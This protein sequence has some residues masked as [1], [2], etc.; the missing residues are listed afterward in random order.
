MLEL[1]GIRVTSEYERRKADLKAA[2]LLKTTQ[3]QNEVFRE[4]SFITSHN[5]RSQVANLKVLVNARLAI[6]LC[7][8]SC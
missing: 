3:S 4:F 1:I 2:K 8:Y 5:I 7:I 6:P